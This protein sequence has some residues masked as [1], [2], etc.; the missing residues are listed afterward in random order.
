[1]AALAVAAASAAAD[2]PLE[3]VW[4]FNG[5]RVAIQAEADG[6][7]TGTVIA[8]TKFAECQHEIGERM[9]TD[10]TA[11]PDGSYVGYHQWFYDG[12]GCIPNPTRGPTAWRVLPAG[13]GRFLRVCLSEPDGPTPTI[14][15]DG[16]SSDATFGCVDSA[17]VSPLPVAK[18]SEFIA[19]P[20]ACVGSDKRLRLRIRNPQSNPLAKV[21]VAVKGGGIRKTF[22]LKPRPKSFVAVL[23]LTPI[24]APTVRA[25]VRLTTVLGAHL[26]HRRVYRRC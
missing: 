7:L 19:G 20:Q 1:V 10:I 13:T 11:R 24:T 18:T 21:S 14:A 25:T 17:P 22:R 4:S 12:S 8:P 15:A 16:E 3:G 5:G 9:W 26:R 23:D 2:S 6:T